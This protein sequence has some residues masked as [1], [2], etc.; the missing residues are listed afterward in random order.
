[1]ASTTGYCERSPAG[2]VFDGEIVVL[3]TDGRPAFNRLLFGRG[4][5]QY[6]AFDILFANG[7]DQRAEPLKA[8]KAL[9]KKILG[10]GALQSDYIV[11]ESG[12][13]FNCVRRFDLE[14]IVAKRISDPYGPPT[15]WIKILNRAY[16]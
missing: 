16:S 10:K 9:L 4:E 11:G 7:R 13:L 5:P 15:K 2:C 1:S 8:R 3:D 14:G 12:P 6:V